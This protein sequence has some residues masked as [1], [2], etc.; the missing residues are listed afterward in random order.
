MTFPAS[1][2]DGGGILNRLYCEVEVPAYVNIGGRSID[3]DEVNGVA[4]RMHLA[5]CSMKIRNVV[6]QEAQ[7]PPFP[8]LDRDVVLRDYQR[9][10][11][12]RGGELR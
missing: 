11:E 4:S 6:A 5:L 1:G 12:Q 9:W 3:A 8:E 10:M 7:W 2:S